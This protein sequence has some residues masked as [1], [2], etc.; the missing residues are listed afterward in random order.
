M[1]DFITMP[2]LE[3][4]A[5]VTLRNAGISGLNG[6]YSS[7]PGNPTYPLI[8]VKRP[9]G[10]PAVRYR[11]DMARIQVDVW[12]GAPGD[13]PKAPTKSV[14]HDIAQQARIALLRLEGRS[15]TSPVPAFI[16]AVVKPL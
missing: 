6:V 9:S 12:G 4:V 8:T 14:I 16:S 1:T 15:V 7:I 10:L 3:A 5:S 13:G 2:D 11:L